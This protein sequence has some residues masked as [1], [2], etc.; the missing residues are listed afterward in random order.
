MGKYKVILVEDDSLVMSI[1]SCY[2]LH[3]KN[4]KIVG[5]F[6]NGKQALEFLEFND[7]DLALV[8]YYMPVMDGREFINKCYEKKIDLD[9]IMITS[10]NG[11]KEVNELLNFRVFDYILKPFTMERFQCAI[12]NWVIRKNIL[13]SQFTLNQK[14]I[15]N[16][17]SN[18]FMFEH[19]ILEKGLNEQTLMKID[20]FLAKCNQYLSSSEIADQIG[21]SRITVR[22]YMNYLLETK[23]VESK[24]DYFTGGRPSIRYKKIN[25]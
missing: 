18:R 5:Q 15:D 17:I 6:K 11:V 22:K 14:D 12:D 3:N 20:G 13:R 23:Q 1:N 7:V 21:L 8:D 4:I 25:V 9:I 10:A 24:I 16:V 19:N 2:L